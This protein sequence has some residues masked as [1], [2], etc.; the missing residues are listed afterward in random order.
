MGF[1]VA[2]R[3]MV[4]VDV[5]RDRNVLYR[6][7]DSGLIENIYTLRVLNKDQTEHRYRIEVDG[8]EMPQLLVDGQLMV[9]SGAVADM[10]LTVRANV[11][12][13]GSREIAVR[14]VAEDNPDVHSQSVATFIAP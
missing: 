4:V 12:F 1:A 10:N 11:S 7:S 9:P 3:D 5:S 14:I 6:E 8:L 13:R 2:N